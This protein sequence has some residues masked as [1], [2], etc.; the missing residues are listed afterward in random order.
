MKHYSEQIQDVLIRQYGW[1]QFAGRS[2]ELSKTVWYP[3]LSGSIQPDGERLIFAQ[4]D[5]SGR[6]LSCVLGFNTLFDIDCRDMK[7][8]EAAR[9]FN[10]RVEA[11]IVQP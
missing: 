1:Q 3:E 10:T 2:N 11:W 6:Y 8:D 4:F 7:P 9:D 5:E